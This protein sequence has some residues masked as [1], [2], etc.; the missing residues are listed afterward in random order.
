[1]ASSPVSCG[2][3]RAVSAHPAAVSCPSEQ[4]RPGEQ[5]VLEEG[6]GLLGLADLQSCRERLVR[7]FQRASP[8]LQPQGRPR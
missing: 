3:T 5:W 1:M 6:L 2:S 4:A 7:G 8:M